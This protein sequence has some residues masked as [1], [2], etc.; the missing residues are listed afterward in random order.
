MVTYT[1]KGA[2]HGG[3]VVVVEICTCI[4]GEEVVV[5]VTCSSK[6]DE[7]AS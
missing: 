2:T 6:E 1:C 5:V 7:E 3:A 4:H